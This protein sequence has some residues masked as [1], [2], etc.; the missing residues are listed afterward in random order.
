MGRAQLAG[1][2]NALPLTLVARSGRGGQLAARLRQRRRPEGLRRRRHGRAAV[3]VA[4]AAACDGRPVRPGAARLEWR[5]TC[6]REPPCAITTSLMLLVFTACF[7]GGEAAAQT[8]AELMA[9]GNQLV[10]SGIYRTAL[11]RYREAA[12]AGLDTPLLHYNLGVVH[13]E[14]GDF[15]ESADEFARAAAGPALGRARELQ[16]RLGAARRRR[17]RGGERGVSRGGGRRR[18]SRPAPA[19]RRRRGGARRREPAAGERRAPRRARRR[20]D[21]AH[22]RARA[23]GRGALGPRRQRLPHAGR[24]LRRSLR[25]DAAA[26]DAR[27]ALGEL[28]AGG[29]ARARTCSTTRPATPSSCSATTWT[30]RST[31]RSSRTRRKSTSAFSMGADIV[32]GESE[33]RRRAVDTAFFV[34][35]H[36]RDELRSRRRLGA[37]HRR[38]SQ[39][40]DRHRGH[41]RP[42]LV[43]GR[44]SAGPFHAHAGP[45]HVGVRPAGSSATS[46]S[47]PSPSRTSTTTIFYTGVD[48]DYDFSDVMTLRLRPA[49]VPD[50]VRR[51]GPHAT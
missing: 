16:P 34:G 41:Q 24:A 43:Q 49:P 42:V 46:T 11:L 30:A 29:A 40:R 6:S 39:R 21:R 31:T 47:A 12:A 14:L 20:A 50:G 17:S 48:I 4:A 8:A 38:S 9:E 23:R 51:R 33:R 18:R 28:H 15:A 32:L 22:R 19:R 10:R 2:D 13:Y 45:R 37:R 44:G 27:R 26:R 7:G 36:Q 1:G 25:S 3:A 5:K 35:T